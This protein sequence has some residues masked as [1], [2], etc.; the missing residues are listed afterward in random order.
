MK[1]TVLRRDWI[2][3]AG[4]LVS[5][6]AGG[7]PHYC[8]SASADEAYCCLPVAMVATYVEV[9]TYTYNCCCPERGCE[10]REGRTTHRYGGYTYQ[11]DC[12]FDPEACAENDDAIPCEETGPLTDYEHESTTALEEGVCECVESGCWIMPPDC[13]DPNAYFLC[14]CSEPENGEGCVVF[15]ATPGCEEPGGED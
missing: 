3:I 8:T 10:E 5:L 4:F 12:G 14:D 15:V 9:S 11:Y 13:L 7:S 6:V 1:T 2:F